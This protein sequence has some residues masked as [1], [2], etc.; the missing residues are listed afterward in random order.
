MKAKHLA[1]A[2]PALFSLSITSEASAANWPILQGTEEGREEVAIEPFGFLQ[3]SFEAVFADEVNG[4]TSAGLS[5]FNGRVA[6]FNTLGPNDSTSTF[7]IARARLG[8][9]G[10][11]PK[12]DRSVNYMV[13]IDA[14]QN[15]LVDGDGAVLVDASATYSTPWTRIRVGQFKLPLLDETTEA[16][17]VTTDIIRFSNVADRLFFERPV[18]DGVFTGNAYAFRDVGVEVFDAIPMGSS[19]LGY[20]A[21]VTNGHMGSVDIGD[22]FDVGGW[23]QWA[24]LL[25]DRRTHPERDELAIYGFAMTGNRD[26]GSETVRRTRVGGGIQVRKD[27]LRVRTEGAFGRGAIPQGSSPPFRGQPVGVLDG[28]AMGATLLAAYRLT[29]WFEV[30]ASGHAL[31][32]AP[33]EG[34]AERDLYEAVLGLQFFASPKAKIAVNGV[35]PVSIAPEGSDDVN[36]ILDSAAPRVVVQATLAF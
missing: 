28:D 10:T 19:E 18:V 20:A 27:K 24:I 4:L 8:V 2:F 30:D 9:R 21:Y 26:L 5:P 14:G 25:D 11:I 29:S 6:V 15:A 16:F 22:G 31:F 7:R 35:L 34:G 3:P 12:T 17:H 1:W 33:G 36:L 13:T 32:L 23:L